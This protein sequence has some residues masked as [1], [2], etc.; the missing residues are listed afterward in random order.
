MCCTVSLNIWSKHY[1]T[2]LS[3]SLSLLLASIALSAA[4]G[5]SAQIIYDYAPPGIGEKL[6]LSTV[7][8]PNG[9]KEPALQVSWHCFYLGERPRVFTVEH[10]ENGDNKARENCEYTYSSF[11]RAMV[12]AMAGLSVSLS[13]YGLRY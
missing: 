8:S 10:G 6:T 11:R 5:G 1:E 2:S 13:S 3:I 7:P 4:D 12:Q 9:K